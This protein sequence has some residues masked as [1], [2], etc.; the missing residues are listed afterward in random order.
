MLSKPAG[1]ATAAKLVFRIQD[2][3]RAWYGREAL[4]IGAGHALPL[5]EG[6]ELGFVL[7]LA[8]A[9]SVG[10]GKAQLQILL[11]P[12]DRHLAD[13]VA[14]ADA[15]IGDQFLR[16]RR[17]R[18]ASSRPRPRGSGLWRPSHSPTVESVTLRAGVTPRRCT[19]VVTDCRNIT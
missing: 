7:I 2:F 14:F 18:R 9:N 13:A 10:P 4:G 11:P 15:L 1:T 17:L 19:L 6:V 8:F 3:R 5:V 16:R 12:A